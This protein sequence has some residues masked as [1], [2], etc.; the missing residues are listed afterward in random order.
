MTWMW[1][2]DREEKA[3]S[4]GIQNHDLDVA[5]PLQGKKVRA[6]TLA[7]KRGPSLKTICC[8]ALPRV[9]FYCPD[10]TTSGLQNGKHRDL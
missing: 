3:T 10:H 7:R 1:K 4:E 9:P 5:H 6:G 2:S 8:P